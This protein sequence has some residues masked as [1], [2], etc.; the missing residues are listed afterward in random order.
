MKNSKPYFSIVILIFLIFIVCNK[1]G[2]NEKRKE[3]RD[4]N[5]DITV[6]Q[7][8]KFNSGKRSSFFTYKYFAKGECYF[9]KIS[10]NGLNITT[11]EIYNVLYDKN[12]PSNSELLIEGKKYDVLK[13]VS[14]GTKINGYVEKVSL[15]SEY[16]DLYIKYKFYDHI[17]SFRTRLRKDSLPCGTIGECKY[18]DL[19]LS[20]YGKYP[21]INDL[22]FKS[23]DRQLI[24]ICEK[25]INVNQKSLTSD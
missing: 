24:S 20:V 11:N 17:F 12:N 8:I 1:K 23:H 18:S 19:Q 7:L 21:L 14:Q 16:V 9:G 13:L 5:P 22:Y 4:Q 15:I 10:D 3:E 25:K 6:G 2:E